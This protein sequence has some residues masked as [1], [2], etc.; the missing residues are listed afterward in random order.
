MAETLFVVDAR[1]SV[2]LSWA[3]DT[4]SFGAIAAAAWFANTQMPASGWI[5]FAIA[6]V[7]VLWMFGKAT[8]LA[9]KKT[10]GEARQWLD[11]TFPQETSTPQ[12]VEA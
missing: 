6:V 7:W 8:N 12:S 3:R 1:E 11:E 10:P 4:Y 9:A 2:W 5:N